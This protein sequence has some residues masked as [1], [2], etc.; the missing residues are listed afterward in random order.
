MRY[1]TTRIRHAWNLEMD[2]ALIEAVKLY[3][4]DNWQVGMSLDHLPRSTVLKAPKLPA[5]SL[6]MLLQLSVKQM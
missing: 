1:G 2:N 6:N 3:G 4:V 5:R